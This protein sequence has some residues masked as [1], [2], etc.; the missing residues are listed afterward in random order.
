MSYD[1]NRD[2]RTH[3]SVQTAR[4]IIMGLIYLISG[5]LVLNWKY[6]GS[7]SLTPAYA[8]I[9]GGIL[10]AYGLFRIYRGMQDMK[11]NRRH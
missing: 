11:M 6:F 7:M 10:C 9:L 4:N 8:Y 5:A 2:M 1:R 3:N